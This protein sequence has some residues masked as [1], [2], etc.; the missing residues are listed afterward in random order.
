MWRPVQKNAAQAPAKRV[1]HVG[2]NRP[3]LPTPQPQNSQRQHQPWQ[4]KHYPPP[5]LPNNLRHP[6]RA[7]RP[8]SRPV[9]G[10]FGFRDTGSQRKSLGSYQKLPTC[11]GELS[12]PLLLDLPLLNSTGLPFD[13]LHSKQLH[14][15]FLV[16]LQMC[17]MKK[18][19]SPPRFSPLLLNQGS[20]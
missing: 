18:V 5:H 17:F 12:E 3:P 13:L 11:S 16:F 8:T 14:D 6:P 4:A 15:L 9:N 20:W 2:R 7:N 1:R 10:G 19:W